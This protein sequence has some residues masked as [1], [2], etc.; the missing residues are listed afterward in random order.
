[1]TSLFPFYFPSLKAFGPA[2]LATVAVIATAVLSRTGRAH[3]VPPVIVRRRL[4]LPKGVAR[5]LA[6]AAVVVATMLALG[7][8]LQGLW[9]NLVPVLSLVA[10]GFVA[11]W[12]IL[13][14]MLASVLIVI[15]R[16]QGI[17]GNKRE[18]RFNV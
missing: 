8:D 10:I 6:I 17:L 18:L 7:V 4:A 5:W 15:F 14:H 12:S 3:N 13:S 1:M 16:P 2:A 11:M 9:S